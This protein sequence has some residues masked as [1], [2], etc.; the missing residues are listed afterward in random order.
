MLQLIKTAKKQK[1]PLVAFNEQRALEVFTILAEQWRSQTGIFYRREGALS[2]AQ[3]IRPAD[4]RELA[5]LLYFRAIPMRGGQ[6]SDLPF[7]WL[8]KMQQL[9]PDVFDPRAVAK[10]WSPARIRELIEE[11][12][13][14]L[15]G[16]KT[17][18]ETKAGAF[19]NKLIE[20]CNAWYNNAVYLNNHWGADFRNIYRGVEDFEE[21][22]GRI[23]YMESFGGVKG[24]RRKIFA[25]LTIWMQNENLIPKF[26]TPLPIDF[27]AL[28]I[29]TNTGILKFKNAKPFVMRGRKLKPD[30]TPLEPIPECYDGRMS[31]RVTERL[32]T[33]IMQW[34]QSFMHTHGIS[35]MH[36]NR[37]L[38]ILS[39][40]ACSVQSQ[41]RWRSRDLAFYDPEYMKKHPNRWMK[42]DPCSYC[43]LMDICTQ[44]VPQKPYYFL[45]LIMLDIGRIPH[46]KLGNQL[47]LPGYDWKSDFKT[48]KTR[49]LP[50]TTTLLP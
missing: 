24:M 23:K 46:P 36:L 18:G 44:A 19:G 10:N 17:T 11:T 42:I 34:S 26:P 27:H 48:R 21:A 16:N 25:L 41:N 47:L 29:L 40:E 22:F 49:M 1:E 3:F 7:K 14:Q 15:I 12:T 8:D 30:G 5:N 37:A 13:T 45:G 39:R 43:P 20:H 50:T 28:R 4:P 33:E 38:W 6:N 35:A 2:E 9:S 31:V 32:V